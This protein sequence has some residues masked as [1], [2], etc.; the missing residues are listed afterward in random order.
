M[1]WRAP[2][3]AWAWRGTRVSLRPRV[4]G[5]DPA[6]AHSHA[7]GLSALS[8]PVSR[9]DPRANRRCNNVGLLCRPLH[10]TC[11]PHA[12]PTSLSQVA[13]EPVREREREALQAVRASS[14]RPDGRYLRV[15]RARSGQPLV[16]VWSAVLRVRGGPLGRRV[17]CAAC[18]DNRVSTRTTFITC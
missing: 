4:C 10:H 13:G 12:R 1:S 5:P 3:A 7:R 14:K 17:T 8:P 11:M 6:T 16:W 9:L 18:R 2:L 15:W